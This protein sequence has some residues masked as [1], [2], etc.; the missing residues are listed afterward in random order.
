MCEVAH[1][2]RELQSLGKHN[3]EQRLYFKVLKNEFRKIN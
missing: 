2:G 1:H 3:K